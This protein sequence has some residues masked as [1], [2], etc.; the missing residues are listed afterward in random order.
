MQYNNNKFIII[1]H[2]TLYSGSGSKKWKKIRCGP[3]FKMYNNNFI[4]IIHYTAPKMLYNDNLVKNRPLFGYKTATFWFDAIFEI[5]DPFKNLLR[6][7][8]F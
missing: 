2:Y 1:T 7:L 5:I 6:Q 8:D 3:G 4:I